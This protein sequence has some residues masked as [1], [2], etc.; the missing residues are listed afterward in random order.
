M[1]VE[2]ISVTPDAEV[3]IEKAGR[4]CYLSDSKIDAGRLVTKSSARVYD[5][6]FLD[7]YRHGVCVGDDLNKGGHYRLIVEAVTE[8]SYVK[9]IKMIIKSGHHSVLEHAYATFKITGG[10]RSM[11]HQ[12]VRHRLCSFSQQSQRYV[13]ENE[14]E[15]V[16]PKSILASARNKDNVPVPSLAMLAYTTIMTQINEAY[17]ALRELKIPKEEARFV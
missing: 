15:Y 7:K 6:S 12:L 16:I 8:P 11:T 2:L 9:F 3:V 5:L 4:T 17:N 14:F 10:S 1:K 13:K